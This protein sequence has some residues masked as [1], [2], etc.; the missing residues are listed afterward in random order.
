M[1]KSSIPAAM[2][3]ARQQLG[4][5]TATVYWPAGSYETGQYTH[6]AGRTTERAGSILAGFADDAPLSI[7]LFYS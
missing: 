3:A 1:Y 6:C 4:Q 2:S 5:Y 7:V